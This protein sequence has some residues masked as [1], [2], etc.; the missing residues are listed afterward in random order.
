MRKLNSITDSIRNTISQSAYIK[1]FSANRNYLLISVFI[2]IITTLITYPGVLYSDSYSRVYSAD[3]LKMTLHAFFDGTADIYQTSVWLTITP[4][5]FIL[6]SK[7]LVGSI[8]LFTISQSIASWFFTY[9]FANQLNKQNHKLWTLLCITASPVMWAFGVFLEAS[10]GC[11]TAI[12]ML[13]LLIW[14]WECLRSRFDKTLTVILILLS[15][16][17][18]F[19][20]RANAIS[21]LP[22]LIIIVLI[23]EKKLLI[24]CAM[25]FPVLLGCALSWMIPRYLYINTMS[26]FAAGF[27]WETVST[28]QTMEPDKREM[29]IDYLDDLF[30]EGATAEAVNESTYSEQGSNINTMFFGSPM[31]ATAI[32]AEGVPGNVVKKYVALAFKEPSAFFKTKLEFVSHTMGI[33]KPVNMAEYDYNRWD[34]MEDYGFNNCHNRKVFVEYFNAYMDSMV[35]LR[36]PWIWYLSALILILVYRFKK[37]GRKSPL[38]LYEATYIVSAFYYGA[39][40]LNTQSFEFRYFYPSWLLLF[41]IIVCLTDN[42]FIKGRK[43]SIISWVT[44][45]VLSALSY[46]GGYRKYIKSGDELLS[47]IRSTAVL[48][49][50]DD[51][52]SIYYS[53]QKL[54]FVADRNSDYV[55]EYYI[56][57][58]NN[59]HVVAKDQFDY[60]DYSVATSFSNK[61][62][63]VM[64]IPDKQITDLKFGQIFELYNIW[65]GTSNLSEYLSCPSEI[66]VSDETND[67]WENGYNNEYNVILAEYRGIED[68]Q[69]NGKY[70]EAPDGSK[71]LI[72]GV[73]LSGNYLYIYT[74]KHL[75]DT[76][77]RTYRVIE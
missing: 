41:L 59:D 42:L 38:N 15:S 26:S 21:I 60:L 20:F 1:W 62:I 23:K 37:Q 18:C 24:R 74:E 53:D 16:Y 14:K 25:I 9:I 22:A 55:Y 77:I 27:V 40:V 34:D 35:I 58:L 8:V 6:L 29:Y 32:S 28:I 4:S 36:M 72:T 44:V 3:M 7:E 46:I 2:S 33:G 43:S 52:N 56:E 65:E 47:K 63:S 76:S 64:D 13:L 11:V 66:E 17:I 39:Y 70:L 54:Y 73:D 68:L 45:L 71:T 57:Y 5:F 61:R 12:L 30:G 51:D 75:S 50:S 49:Y 19:G 69:I 67:Y 48:L 31:D 10:V